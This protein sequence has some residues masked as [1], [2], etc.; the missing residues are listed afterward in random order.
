G[1]GRSRPATAGDGGFH[2]SSYALIAAHR[3]RCASRMERP[4]RTPLRSL[5]NIA[6]AA[7]TPIAAGALAIPP[8]ALDE[9]YRGSIQMSYEAPK[10]PAL[11]KAYEMAKEANA[12]E[13]LR[14]VFVS[15][16]LP[17]DLYIKTVSCDGIPNAYFSREND[18][19][20]I[21]ICYEYLQSL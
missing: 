10:T 14:L 9:N 2:V 5:L 18:R 4:M 6:M 16:R 11:Q 1:S 13:M 15:F 20:T 19:P 3:T 8:G 7:A 12:L 17:E 21:R